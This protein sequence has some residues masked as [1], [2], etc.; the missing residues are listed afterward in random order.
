MLNVLIGSVACVIRDAVCPINY[1]ECMMRVLY[2][3]ICNETAE[4]LPWLME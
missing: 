4:E 3:G 2:C 1:V